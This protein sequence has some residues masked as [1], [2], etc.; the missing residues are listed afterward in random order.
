MCATVWRVKDVPV[1]LW[2]SPQSRRLSSP[3]QHSKQKRQLTWVPAWSGQSKY[4]TGQW[5]PASLVSQPEQTEACRGPE[6]QL[7]Q[8]PWA[9]GFLTENTSR[10][11]LT[12]HWLTTSQGFTGMWATYLYMHSNRGSALPWRMFLLHKSSDLLRMERHFIDK[13]QEQCSD[14]M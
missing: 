9:T 2:A 3:Q 5:D 13:L 6:G 4:W 1:R 10:L 12:A 7:S 11:L 14:N 8:T